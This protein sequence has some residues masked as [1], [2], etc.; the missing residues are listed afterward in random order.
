MKTSR[1]YLLAIIALLGIAAFLTNAFAQQAFPARGQIAFCDLVSVF[2][3][4]QR[5]KDLTT[6]LNDRR[7]AIKAESEKRKKAVDTLSMELENYKK[8]SPQYDQTFN[9]VTR[10]S[11]E[12][13]AYL[14]YQEQLALRDHRSLTEEMYKE[15]IAAVAKV[16]AQQG[17]SVV[18]QREQEQLNTEDTKAML[19]QIYNRKV[20][21]FNGDLD[22]T[23]IVLTSL[24][25]SYKASKPAAPVAPATPGTR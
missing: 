1:I 20:L 15:I 13:D 4:Y 2:N 14:R 24:N 23:E 18:M 7:N 16:A 9:E 25:Q 3:N 8:G 10:Q 21:Y 6:E 5:A 17:V 22:I 11:I 12:L 19:Q